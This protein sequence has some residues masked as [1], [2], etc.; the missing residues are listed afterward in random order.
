MNDT[1][2]RGF[3]RPTGVRR[4][5][6]VK[7][8]RAATVS[9]HRPHPPRS[10][11]H[12]EQLRHGRERGDDTERARRCHGRGRGPDK[13]RCDAHVFTVG[14]AGRCKFYAE[15]ASSST[16]SPR[17]TITK[18]RV[19]SS[20]VAMAVLEKPSFLTRTVRSSSARRRRT[21]NMIG[22]TPRWLVTTLKCALKYPWHRTMLFTLREQF[23][24]LPISCLPTFRPRPPAMF[25]RTTSPRRSSP[26]L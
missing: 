25:H 24:L 12:R 11:E 17:C 4:K 2:L 6:F 10:P 19:F 23:S 3:L 16:S 13:R 18:W 15:R 9:S 8:T 5:R 21:Q 20:L 14:E 7:P 22:G 1:V 26:I